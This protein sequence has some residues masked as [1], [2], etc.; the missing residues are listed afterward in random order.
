MGLLGLWLALALAL[1]CL[2]TAQ[3]TRGINVL[4]V[5]DESNPV[6]EKALDVALNYVRRTASTGIQFDSFQRVIANTSDARTLLEALCE[7]YDN[8]LKTE[9]PPDLVL[10]FTQTGVTS[11]TVKSFTHALALPTVSASY[12]QEDDLRQWRFLADDQMKYLVQ[13][14]PPADMIP[15]VI[16]S[17]VLAWNISNA[18]ILFDDSFVMDHKYKSLL[19]NVPTR[20]LIAAVE[21]V[22][23]VKRQL[24]RLRELDIVNF[25][26]LGRLATLKNVLD[27]ANANKYFGR[28]FAWFAITQDKGQLKCSASNA[29][30]LFL[31]PEPD[32]TS[33]ERLEKLRTDFS[34]TTEPEI[35]S[36]F[37][38]DLALRSFLSI[39]QMMDKG[40]WKKLNYVSCEEYQEDKPMVRRDLELRR[41]LREVQEP[42]SYAPM[43]LEEH[44]GHSYMEASMRLEKVTVVNGQSV[45]AEVEG[46]WKLGLDSPLS[47]KDA[48]SIA[49]LTAASVYRIVTVLQKPFVMETRD[50][51]GAVKYEG[52]CIDLL[53]E[54]RKIIVF[55]Y[56]IYVAPDNKF[57]NMDE[58]GQWD[59]MIK[60][61]MEKRAD[62]GL[63]SLA[64]M[65]ERENVID[66]T[67]PYYDLVGISI[68][69]KK[70]ETP[71]SLFKFLTVLE[72]EVWLCI[73]AAYFFTSFLMW[74]FDRWSPYS[75][76][77]NREKYKDDEE[78]REFNLKECLWFCMTSLTPQGGGEAPKNLS[79]R[80]VAATWWLFG[81]IIIASYTAN[82]AAFL[83]VSRLDTPVESLDD[84]SKQ[85]K[86]QY[87]PYNGSAAMTYF[88]R[89]ADIET[90]FYE[91][92]K[93]MS[94]NDSLSE[95]ERA[96]LAVWDYPVGDKYTKMWQAM[97]D[98]KMPNNLE[99][100]VARVRLSEGTSEGF[101]YLG[102][103]T[104]IRY[105]SLTNCDLQMVGEEFSRKPYAIAVQ[106]GSPLKDQF[107]N[108]IL[109]LLNKRKLE[110]LKERW[111]STNPEIKKCDKQDDQQDGI[112]IQNIG[113]VFI[114]IFVGIGLACVTLAFEYYWYKYK[115]NP[116]VTDLA[117]QRGG[118]APRQQHLAVIGRGAS[119]DLSATAKLDAAALGAL[120]QAYNYRRNGNQL[121]GVNQAWQH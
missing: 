74:V 118:K 79:G 1:P 95:V 83:T 58:K 54:I 66:F 62:I 70:P 105:L 59:G 11:E 35:A 61:L 76:Q 42:P 53:D 114:V 67:V 39:K 50:K 30:I 56:E 37:Y 94:L 107:N 121:P 78:K 75:Y 32:P 93:D 64:V 38:F 4:F 52:Y 91:I 29:T 69:M 26:V 112:S 88:Q 8:S 57:G 120:G 47:V 40:Q 16:R 60:E 116:R 68:L 19:Q 12:G 82:L 87:A 71:T 104:D 24:T 49:N 6:A 10:D 85:Y 84:L 21:D 55:E 23:N 5:S 89:M 119:D 45:S 115:R 15:E 103:A 65:A 31:K 28:K 81:F 17:I 110:K 36:A 96:K 100:A 44:N 14:S 80:L 7:K 63:G 108:A 22:R 27:A 99:E 106:Q 117:G 25:F 109:Q 48:S 77:N 18:G 33:R 13:V 98:A 72:R 51:S 101:A 46:S 90:R 20:H 9:K 97:L 43:M 92:W 102:D 3:T 2:T 86:I 111:W 41:A 113:G 34:L 73:L